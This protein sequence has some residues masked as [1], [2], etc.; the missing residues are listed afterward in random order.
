MKIKIYLL[1]ILTLSVFCEKSNAQLPPGIDTNWQ[2]NTNLSDEFNTLNLSKWNVIDLWQGKCC[3][4]GGNSRFATANTSVQN[5]ELVLK[6]DAPFSGATPP[7][8][9][10]ECCNTG[11]INSLTESYQYG[12]IE[13][14]A[15]LPGNYYNGIPNAQKFQPAF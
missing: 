15:K 13:I 2:L 3:N 4:W 5:G 9:F 1:A 10:T 8:D 7:Y 12:Y 14:Y 11:G 6:A